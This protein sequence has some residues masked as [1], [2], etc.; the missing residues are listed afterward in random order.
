[1]M[2]KLSVP[3]TP[4][5]TSYSQQSAQISILKTRCTP[6]HEQQTSEVYA[7]SGISYRVAQCSWY[8]VQACTGI[9]FCLFLVQVNVSSV[10]PSF[11][12]FY[13]LA[14]F[15]ILLYIHADCI[16]TIEDPYGWEFFS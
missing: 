14:K 9:L 4:L 1:M 13:P 6:V 8:A 16:P 2:R 10:V 15:S 7:A 5:C 11:C 12:S 3:I